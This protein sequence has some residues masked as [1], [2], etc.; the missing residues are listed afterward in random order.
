MV[1]MLVVV[2]VGFC[3]LCGGGAAGFCGGACGDCWWWLCFLWIFFYE[4]VVNGVFK[5][6]GGDFT[7]AELR[8]NFAQLQKRNKV[9]LHEFLVG[10]IVIFDGFCNGL[11]QDLFLLLLRRLDFG[12]WR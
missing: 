2:G 9:R 1:V 12:F 5:Y 4:F 10:L 8:F 6:L 7:C 11:S 3:V